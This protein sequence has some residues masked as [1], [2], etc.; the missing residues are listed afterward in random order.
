MDVLSIAEFVAVA[1]RV[2]TPLT[3]A[4]L[5]VLI[6]TRAGVL[7][8]GIEGMMLAGAFAGVVVS[9]FTGSALLGL[10]FAI[11]TGAALGALLAAAVHVAKA[12]LILS[13]IA[14]NIAA[15]AGTTLLLFLI[16]GSKGVS[17][18][19]PSKTLPT[20]DIPLLGDLP[21][22]GTALSGHHVLTYAAFLAAPLV[23]LFLTRT[24]VGIR[25]RAVGEK[26][27]AAA[28]AGVNVRRY[29][30]WA[31]A[32]SGAFGGVAGAFL[33]MGYVSWFGQNMT[34][35]RGFIALAAEVMGGGSALG[36]MLSAVVLGTAETISITMQGGGLPSEL[37]QT[38]PYIVPILALLVHAMRRRRIARK[39]AA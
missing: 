19:L 1:L 35:G 33:S 15:A 4:A 28:A 32:A 2:S 36:T 8:I 23:A 38:V 24:P 10:V 12:D 7:N 6:S 11:V 22:V 37:V 30:F 20:I 9:A 29:Q 31:L 34:A 17:S 26:P 13:G 39:S 5:G 25:L 14:I 18:S 21:L 27:E 3:L 16:T